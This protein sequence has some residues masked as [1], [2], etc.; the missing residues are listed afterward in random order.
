MN[1]VELQIMF[2]QKIVDVNPVF[3]VEERPDTFTIV[4]YLNKSIN[5]YLNDKF[6]KLPTLEH[7]LLAIEANRDDLRFLIVRGGV[8][9]YSY[10]MDTYNWGSRGKRYRMPDNVLIPLSLSATVSREEVAPM[11]SQ[12][13]F[14]EWRSRKQAERLIKDT[15]DQVIHVRPVA[16]LEDEFYVCVLGDAY[17]TSID[18][19]ELSYLRQP[20]VLSFDYNELT[21]TATLDITSVP[22]GTNMKA[23]TAL[24]YVNAS[25]T[26]TNYIA[27]EK[28]V[29]VAGYNTITA[30]GG[31][32]SKIG[33]PFGF[34]DTPDFPSYMHEDI[35]NR[36]TTLFLD[37]AKLKLVPKE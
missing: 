23:L 14:A 20:D 28:V 2:Q 15:S 7:Q 36:A 21:G 25:G 5:E 33:Y 8:L 22:D 16:F 17:V 37:E 27:G 19:N 30:L 1:L 26:P 32:P 3:D 9:Q 6:I 34:T 24:I 29:K 12:K 10:A 11:T 18:A 31:E 4:N 13:M 35:L